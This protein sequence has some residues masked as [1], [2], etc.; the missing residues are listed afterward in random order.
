MTHYHHKAHGLAVQFLEIACCCCS[1]GRSQC[2]SKFWKD[3]CTESA[4]VSLWNCTQFIVCSLGERQKRVA[5]PERWL[6]SLRWH[7]SAPLKASIE[8]VAGA[9]AD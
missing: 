5:Y 3:S 9:N 4:E 1:S 8:A 7:S 6:Y 2:I